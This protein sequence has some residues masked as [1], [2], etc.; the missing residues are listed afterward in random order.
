[1]KEYGIQKKK[2]MNSKRCSMN[3][4]KGKQKKRKN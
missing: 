2:W 3:F 1:M 4:F